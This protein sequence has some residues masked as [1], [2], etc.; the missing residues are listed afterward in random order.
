MR[1]Q[2]AHPAEHE[3]IVDLP[4]RDRLD[5]WRMS[6]VHSVLGLHRHVVKLVE[7]DDVSYVVKELPDDLALREYRLLRELAEDGLPTVEAVAAVTDRA[8][9]EALIITRHLD[10]SLPYRSLLMGRGLRIPYL[11]E[12]LLDALVVLLVRIHLAGFFWGDC[13]LSNTLF[14]RAAGALQ[15]YISDL[16]TAERH[17]Q[18]TAGLRSCDLE[19][20]TQNGAG[21]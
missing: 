20:A 16:E 4:Y 14:R 3:P 19:I 13:S 7:Y 5:Q 17:A 6:N 8:C 21:G 9:G 1:V 18:L 2:V 15:A 11:G 10:Y 12:R